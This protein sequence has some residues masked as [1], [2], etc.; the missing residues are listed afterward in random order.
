MAIKKSDLYSSIWA[1]CNQLR[2]GMDATQYKDYV[3]LSGCHKA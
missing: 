2:S 3:L 1:L